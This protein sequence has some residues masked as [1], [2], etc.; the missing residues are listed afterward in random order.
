[1]CV[2]SMSFVCI[3][4]SLFITLAG[5]RPHVASCVSSSDE[6]VMVVVSITCRYQYYYFIFSFFLDL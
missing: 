2:F 5:A 1:M 4:I 6:E 3:A